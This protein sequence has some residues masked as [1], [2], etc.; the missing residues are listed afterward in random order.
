MPRM[1]NKESLINRKGVKKYIKAQ[2]E[3]HRQGWDCTN[4]SAGALDQ[5]EAFVRMKVRESV[6]RHPTRGKTF[7]EFQ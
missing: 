2:V 3:A 1:A 7:K 6:Q 4:V 5:I